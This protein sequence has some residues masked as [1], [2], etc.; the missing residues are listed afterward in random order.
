MFHLFLERLAENVENYRSLGSERINS[1]MPRGCF[2]F[3]S[4]DMKNGKYIF[5]GYNA[6][7][8]NGKPA[9]R[10]NCSINHKRVIPEALKYN[11][12]SKNTLNESVKL[13]G[14]VKA[15]RK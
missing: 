12:T 6:Q 8:N 11:Y 1:W 13:S 10:L 2:V 7:I 15:K 3:E 4:K 5:E 14:T 9:F